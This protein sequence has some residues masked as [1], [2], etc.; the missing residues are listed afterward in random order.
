[1]RE[2][3]GGDDA[4]GPFGRCDAPGRGRRASDP[5]GGGGGDSPGCGAGGRDW[6][7][8]AVDERE[9]R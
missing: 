6:V 5:W 9:C 1:M 4:R 3:T 7:E 8:R 2:K